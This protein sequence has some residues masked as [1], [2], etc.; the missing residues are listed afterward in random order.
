MHDSKSFP[1][2]SVVPWS[3]PMDPVPT[4]I[5]ASSGQLENQSIVQQFTKEG[6]FNKRYLKMS[7]K[8]DMAMT[9]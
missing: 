1:N 2:I 3:A 6:N 7:P 8:G 9:Q 5:N 4:E